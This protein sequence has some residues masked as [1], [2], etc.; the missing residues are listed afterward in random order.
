MQQSTRKGSGLTLYA[1]Q[2]QNKIASE[3]DIAGKGKREHCDIV[4]NTLG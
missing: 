4:D 1:I 2:N 3:S